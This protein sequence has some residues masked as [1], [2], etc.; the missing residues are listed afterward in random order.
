MN[1][2]IFALNAGGFYAVGT[3][4]VAAPDL[5]TALKLANNATDAKLDLTYHGI[6]QP[7]PV[8]TCDAEAPHIINIH[9]WG[10]PHLPSK[11]SGIKVTF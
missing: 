3:V 8:G 9:E 2:N 6:M 7:D 1:L 4:V 11:G 5:P 10:M